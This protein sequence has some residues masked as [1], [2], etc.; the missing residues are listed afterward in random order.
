MTK[1]SRNPRSPFLTR[2]VL[3]L[4]FALT[5]V[6]CGGLQNAAPRDGATP[7]VTF[8]HEGITTGCAA[9]HDTNQP[10][11]ALPSAG[12]GH[13]ATGGLDCSNCHNADNTTGWTSWAGGQ[14]HTPGSSTPATCL[15]C[16]GSEAPTSTAGW[17]STTYARSPFDY[18]GNS[19]GIS[20][21]GGQDCAICHAGPGAG[22]WG[23]QPNWVGGQFAHVTFSLADNTCIACHASQRPD[24]QPGATAETA[25][26]QVGFD[27]APY[28]ALDC[29]GC[30]SATVD[31]D[32]YVNYFNPAT[33][34]LPGGDWQGGRSFPGSVPVGYPG[35]H[36]EFQ[37]TT[38]TL[39]SANDFVTDAT[40]AWEEVRDFM[41]HTS[42]AIPPELRPAPAGVPDYGKCWHCHY[43]KNGVV[44][45]Y[46]PGKFHP[47]LVQYAV[48]PD[49]PVTPLPQPTQGC[50]ECHAATQ[51]KGIVGT[52]SLQPMNHGI[53]FASPTIVAGVSATGVKDLDCSACHENP[54]GV[55]R[56]VAFHSNIAA[57]TLRE[58]VSCHYVTMADGPT[59]DVQSGSAY[60]MRHTS[61]QMT[62]HT[63]TTCHP[64]AL[65]N[66]I[67]PTLAAESW[68]PG[69]YHAVLTVQ[70]TGCNDCHSESVPTASIA[71]FDHSALTSPGGGRDCGGCHAFPGTGTTTTP[72]WLGAANP[73]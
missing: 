58:C 72:N 47:A 28:S 9:C 42:T 40:V 35:E 6:G 65:A 69:Q 66:A 8:D 34:A 23:N 68:R 27:H 48:T 25:V 29:M 17:R 32:S 51:P 50:K 1:R 12:A 2:V 33:S 39:S 16:H 26:A 61:A 5:G 62:F 73:S 57:A 46:P 44:I 41:I 3:V 7:A 37:T 13:R 60:R 22:A 71:A 56:D 54:M 30:H 11:A 38:I 19:L 21:G 4:A 59:A 24:L 18:S 52:S 49:A 10:Y 43:N 36:L 63:C 64:S 53:E 45:R 14:F 55:F 20:H 67:N 70:P 15:P 31:A